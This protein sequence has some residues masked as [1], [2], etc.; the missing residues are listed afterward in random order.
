MTKENV[1]RASSILTRDL[2]NSFFPWALPIYSYDSFLQAIAKY[3]KFCG[4]AA[5][6]DSDMENACK[7]E[8]STILAHIKHESTNLEFVEEIACTTGYVPGNDCSYAEASTLYPP[9]SGQEYYGRGAFQLSWNYNYA[10]FA[11]IAFDGELNDKY[12]LL[13]DPSQVASDGRLAFLSAI[14]FYIYPQ[15]PKPS[16]HDVILGY[17]TPSDH[18]LEQNLCTNCFG[19]TINIINGGLE[20]D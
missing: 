5:A 2:W 15:A 10:Q 16:M 14:W 1:I 4:E 3:P 9:V 8:L 7:L 13:N 12:T 17:Y 11:T 6:F 18:G 20:C 19:T